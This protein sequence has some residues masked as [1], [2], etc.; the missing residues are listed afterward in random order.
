MPAQIDDGWTTSTPEAVGLDSQ[1]L[2]G[3]V[4]WLDSLAASGTSTGRRLPARGPIGASFS[5]YSTGWPP[6]TW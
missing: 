5:A 1:V 6:A 2:C 4:H 3:L